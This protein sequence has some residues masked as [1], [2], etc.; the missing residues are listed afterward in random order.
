MIILAVDLGKVRTGVAICD[1]GEI[2]ASPVEVI[3]EHNREN[4]PPS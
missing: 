1:K 3:T 4:K 2:L